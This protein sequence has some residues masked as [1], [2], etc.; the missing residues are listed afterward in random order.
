MSN[1]NLYTMYGIEIS[2]VWKVFCVSLVAVL[3]I[4]SVAGS[5]K[6][7]NSDATVNKPLCNGYVSHD[8]HYHSDGTNG[9]EAYQEWHASFGMNGNNKKS[10]CPS[11]SVDYVDISDDDGN[12]Y[13]VYNP[14][15]Y[16]TV[17]TSDKGWIEGGDQI[18]VYFSSSAATSSSVTKTMPDPNSPP[19]E[20][21]S[22]NPSDGTTF[23]D[24]SPQLSVYASDPDNEGLDVQFYG[25]SGAQTVLDWDRENDGDTLSDL[26]NRMDVVTDY[27][28]MYDHT[29]NYLRW[30]ESSNDGR[31]R[32]RKQLPPGTQQVELDLHFRVESYEA[33]GAQFWVEDV[34]GNRY[35][36]Q[37]NAG[38]R[39]DYFNCDTDRDY[40]TYDGEFSVG[41]PAELEYFYMGSD[42]E[43]ALNEWWDES[44]LY[45]MTVRAIDADRIAT[46]TTVDGSGD[47]ASIEWSNPAC[48]QNKWFARVV[49]DDNEAATSGS[50]YS[51]T[52]NCEMP[53]EN[54]SNLQPS[55][56]KVDKTPQISAS[57]SDEN[58]DDGTLYFETPSGNS[59]GSCNVQN[60]AGSCSVEYSSAN[61]WGTQYSF[62]VYAEDSTGRT[63]GRSSQ[64]FTTNRKPQSSNLRP[65][66]SGVGT[67]PVLRADV[68]DPDNGQSFTVEFFNADSG[69]SLGTDSISSEGEAS[70][71][72]SGLQ[73][74]SEGGT[75]YNFRT[76]V[77]DG[78]ASSSSSQSFTT[79]YVPVIESYDLLDTSKNHRLTVSSTVSDQDGSGNIDYCELHVKDGDGHDMT[80]RI[81]DPTGGDTSND[82]TCNFGSVGYQT[83]DEWT[84]TEELNFTLTVE[85]A[86]GEITTQSNVRQ[87]P[88]H[89]PEIGTVDFTNYRDREAFKIS[90]IIEYPDAGSSEIRSC[91]IVIDDGENSYSVGTM[92]KIDSSKVR[93]EV[94]NVGPDQFSGIRVDEEL[95]VTVRATD[96]HGKTSTF[97]TLYNVPTGIDYDYTAM[98]LQSGG[99]DFLDYTVSNNADGES[100]F[101]TTIEG[102]NATFTSNGES[103]IEYSLSQGQTSSLRVKVAPEIGEYRTKQLKIVTENLNTGIKQ[104]HKMPVDIR[105]NVQPTENIVPGI[106]LV[107][108]LVLISMVGLIY[109]RKL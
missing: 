102:V 105:Q 16:H 65:T 68:S 43:N 48:A 96:S 80:D 54:P 82:A 104:V 26:R 98:M 92:T 58:N 20:P 84:H 72:T 30:A 38:G 88:N 49:E 57:Y 106:S 69:D 15:N 99:I 25:G 18:T 77:S 10:G 109:V 86:Q 101:R 46:D 39:Y 2:D 27:G 103:E 87:L 8:T 71:D 81:D 31:M 52:L 11:T 40:H 66:G 97:K 29:T 61:Q 70:L 17:R 45:S 94:D 79:N 37:C 62:E 21:N 100:E 89:G 83:V 51:F 42:M 90:S 14:G 64:T 73:F 23:Q 60:G 44:K 13:R 50:V 33:S 63:S 19:N 78:L 107:Q 12:S 22:P 59:I 7:K 75:T 47:T 56:S 74:G 3:L 6:K 36:I 53:P 35:P 67:N 24:R 4:S 28:L 55:G 93:C 76:E 34:N 41:S 108:I 85:D 1:K 91:N 9:G 5:K 95:T 32:Y